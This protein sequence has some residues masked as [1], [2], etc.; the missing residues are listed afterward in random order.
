M[1]A[2]A[3]ADTGDDTAQDQ[4]YSVL[5]WLWDT[6]TEPVLTHLR[7]TSGSGQRPR[8]WWCPIGVCVALPLHAAGHHTTI[9]DGSVPATVMDRAISSYTP[10]IRALECARAD[11]ATSHPSDSSAL[12][13][14]MPTTQ[15]HQIS[16][17]WQTKPKR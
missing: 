7:L 1:A 2:G 9:P 12:I 4:V 8:I 17:R 16:P 6:I 5:G 14:A 15:V 13:V 11:R 3:A 10:T